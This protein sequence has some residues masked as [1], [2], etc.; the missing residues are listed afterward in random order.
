MVEGPRRV[1]NFQPGIIVPLFQGTLEQY[2]FATT[3]CGA[4]VGAPFTVIVLASSKFSDRLLRQCTSSLFSHPMVASGKL[5]KKTNHSFCRQNRRS[6]SGLLSVSCSGTCSNGGEPYHYKENLKLEDSPA[7][8]ATKRA[9]Q[10][11]VRHRHGHQLP[12]DLL[13]QA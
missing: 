1:C 10:C 4:L 13:P 12:H 9:P 2:P 8:G 6:A 3:T 5:K 11:G 7:P